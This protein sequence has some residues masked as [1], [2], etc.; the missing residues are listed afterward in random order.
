MLTPNLAAIFASQSYKVYDAER[1]E[2][3]SVSASSWLPHGYKAKSVRQ[4]RQFSHRG[5][6][7]EIAERQR[8]EI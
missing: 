3:C 4:R 6:V 7:D 1:V 5:S 8:S 2:G